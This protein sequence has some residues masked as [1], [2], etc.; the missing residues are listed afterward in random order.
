MANITGQTQIA[1][2]DIED[3]RSGGGSRSQDSPRP[4][5]FI[6]FVQKVMI[7]FLYFIEH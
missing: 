3:G 1:N 7:R 5:I 6:S 4:P 2:L